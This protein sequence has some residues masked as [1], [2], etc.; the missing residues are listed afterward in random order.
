MEAV[1]LDRVRVSHRADHLSGRDRL[2][3]FHL[4]RGGVGV[5]GV[6]A[7]A[8]IENDR[9]PVA[10]KPV[11]ELHHPGLD[12]AH[13]SIFWDYYP[14]NAITWGLYDHDLTPKPLA[15][16][17][18]LLARTIAPDAVRLVPRYPADG[19]LEDGAELLPEWAFV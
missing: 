17:Y 11:D 15:F 8:M 1:P 12:R 19:R 13:H 9:A 7:G 5:E 6:E 3:P 4:H 16:T 18:Q 2:A 14:W 10:W